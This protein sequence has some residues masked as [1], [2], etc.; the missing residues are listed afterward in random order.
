M[1]RADRR[2]RRSQ[3]V[4][5]VGTSWRWASASARAPRA[6]GGTR[7]RGGRS[8]RPGAGT[9]CGAKVLGLRATA[10]LGGQEAGR[11]GANRAGATAKGPRGP[12]LPT[13]CQPE[14]DCQQDDPA[15]RLSELSTSSADARRPSCRQLTGAWVTKSTQMRAVAGDILHALRPWQCAA[16]SDRTPCRPRRRWEPRPGAAAALAPAERRVRHPHGELPPAARPPLR[17]ASSFFGG[18]PSPG[19][20]SRAAHR[21]PGCAGTCCVST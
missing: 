19:A 4:R 1:I 13:R 18:T 17:R 7:R 2:Q 5:G 10:G 14:A 8:R 21:R 16:A 11:I 15:G 6:R 20:R 12:H 3:L 9:A